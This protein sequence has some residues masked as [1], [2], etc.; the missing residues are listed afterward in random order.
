MLRCKTPFHGEYHV[1]RPDDI[2]RHSGL[3]LRPQPRMDGV[4]REAGPEGAGRPRRALAA[5]LILVTFQKLE[6][7]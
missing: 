4:V 5:Q 2:G 6:H 7:S 1:V 3:R